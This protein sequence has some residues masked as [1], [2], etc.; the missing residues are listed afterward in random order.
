MTMAA[1]CAVMCC[2]GSLAAHVFDALHKRMVWQEPKRA[3]WACLPFGVTSV[4]IGVTPIGV[5]SK[6]VGPAHFTAHSRVVDIKDGSC[7][8]DTQGELQNQYF[9]RHS[10]DAMMTA[11]L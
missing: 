2:L 7:T 6:G 10:Q 8:L 3:R 4:S 5:E 11:R 1:S 9:V